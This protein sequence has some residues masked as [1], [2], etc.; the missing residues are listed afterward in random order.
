MFNLLKIICITVNENSKYDISTFYEYLWPHMRAKRLSTL[1]CRV[2]RLDPLPNIRVVKHD[3]AGY[4]TWAALYRQTSKLS[5]PSK[6]PKYIP[7]RKFDSS[8]QSAL[9]RISYV[10]VS[11]ALFPRNLF[12]L[13]TFKTLFLLYRFHFFIDLLFVPFT[14][15]LFVLLS[16]FFHG[17]NSDQVQNFIRGIVHIYPIFSVRKLVLTITY[18]QRR[19]TVPIF[20]LQDQNIYEQRVVMNLVQKFMAYKFVLPI[21]RLVF[22]QTCIRCAREIRKDPNVFISQWIDARVE[23]RNRLG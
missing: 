21:T 8:I 10:F 20:F 9:P 4:W 7:R 11:L 18:S 19:I 22:N 16:T 5:P 14:A 23:I 12:T 6:P 2:K 1:W 17:A 13:Y 15:Q 3:S